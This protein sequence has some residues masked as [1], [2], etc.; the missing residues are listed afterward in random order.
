[1]IAETGSEANSAFAVAEEPEPVAWQATGICCDFARLT[2]PVK[3]A[4]SAC[5]NAD[6]A[7]VLANCFPFADLS[8]QVD[9]QKFRGYLLMNIP[10]ACPAPGS[11]LPATAKA[12]ASTA[13]HP[14]IGEIGL[15]ISATHEGG[16][17]RWL[18]SVEVY[19]CGKAAGE[20]PG[21]WP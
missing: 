15:D 1:M 13:V 10:V 9:L 6:H 17:F 5:T 21:T 14:C 2:R 18:A 19:F 8:Q 12:V 7:F 11:A 16:R 20:Q 4:P 3:A